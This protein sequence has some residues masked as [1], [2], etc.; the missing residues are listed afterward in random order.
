MKSW[1]KADTLFLLMLLVC[2][3]VMSIGSEPW[4]SVLHLDPA[5]FT[6]DNR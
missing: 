5:I 3:A 4:W 6:V 2:V 1:D